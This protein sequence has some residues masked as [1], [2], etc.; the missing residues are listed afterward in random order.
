MTA[1]VASID[2][3]VVGSE[4]EALL[5]EQAFIRQYR[6]RFNIRL[7][8]DKSYP[9]IGISLDEGTRACTSHAS[10]TAATVPTSVRTRTPSACGRRSSCSAACS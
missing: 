8:D 5:T 9:F 6:P 10:A 4:S 2:N 3:V 7:R 1:E